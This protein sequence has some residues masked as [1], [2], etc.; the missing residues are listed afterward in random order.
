MITE[1]KDD[2]YVEDD[3]YYLLKIVTELL[4]RDVV[5]DGPDTTKIILVNEDGK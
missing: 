3:E 5:I 4:P 1:R 2:E